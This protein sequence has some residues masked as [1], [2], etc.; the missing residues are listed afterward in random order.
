MHHIL[1]K[2]IEIPWPHIPWAKVRK[3]IRIF[4]SVAAVAIFLYILTAP[5]ILKACWKAQIRQS[6]HVHWVRFYAPLLL[7][8]EDD[9]PVI[10][11]PFRW[12]FNTVWGCGIIFFSDNPSGKTE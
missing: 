4:V 12:Y 7:G 5:P 6:Q 10:H 2:R 9:S 11:G 8:L 3:G 1:T